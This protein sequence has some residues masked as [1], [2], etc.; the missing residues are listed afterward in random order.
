MNNNTACKL[1]I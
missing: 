1:R